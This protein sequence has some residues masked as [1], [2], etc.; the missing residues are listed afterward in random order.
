ME[1]D[2]ISI[3]KLS[4]FANHG[5]LQTEKDNGQIF[6]VSVNMYLSLRAPG[7]SDNLRE[8][9]NYAEVCELITETMQKESC[10]LI[11]TVAEKVASQIMAAF[12]LVDEI[13]VKISKPNAPIEAEFGDVSVTIHRK[14]HTVYLSVGSN[15]GDKEAY[16]DF[17]IGRLNVLFG[18]EVTKKSSYILTEPYGNTNQDDFLNGCLELKTLYEPEELLLELHKIETM[19]GR[20]RHVHWGPRTLDLDIIFYDD[21]I[22]HSENLIIPHADLEHRLFV[23]KPLME[24]APY[25]VDPL[26]NKN[27]SQL[28]KKI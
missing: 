7:Q 6:Y 27:V 4:V 24:I 8:S 25:K 19:A 14:R 5:V 17:G 28:F 18:C 3:E 12:R 23:L 26:S 10:A 20:E 2:K 22:Y 9:V 21:I 11:E 13:D 15:V 16:L 1:K